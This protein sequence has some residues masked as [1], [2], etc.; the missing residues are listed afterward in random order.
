MGILPNFIVKANLKGY[1]PWPQE[2]DHRMSCKSSILLILLLLALYSCK[3]GARQAEAPE[4]PD[5]SGSVDSLSNA[6]AKHNMLNS[7][8]VGI[9]GVKTEQWKRF[10]RLS[11]IATDKELVAL[12]DHR[13]AVVRCYAFEAL[14]KRK[15]I[16]P[17]PI[18]LRHLSDTAY[19]STLNGC[20]GRERKAGDIFLEELTA[21]ANDPAG[22]RL[23]QSQKATVDSILVFDKNNSLDA[24]TALLLSLPPE[25]KYYGRLREMATTEQNRNA[26]IPLSR[27][28]KQQDK[29]LIAQLL[30][31]DDR[32]LQ[33]YGLAAVVHFPDPSFFPLLKKIA[34]QELQKETVSDGQQ[35]AMLYMAIVRYKD[36]P[37]RALLDKVLKQ[38]KGETFIRHADYIHQALKEYPHPIYN[39]L[40]D[41]VR[42]RLWTRG[43]GT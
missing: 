22:Y 15:H 34:Q 4:L 42:K 5:L 29:P 25:S 41:Q 31:Q 26:L 13:N 11:R 36:Q 28:Q 6:I 10:E 32:G 18:L 33:Y 16:D 24:K 39:G 38:A 7:A 3:S 40:L 27:Y 30:Q 23:T 8:A 19:V 12:T 1:W 9:A 35:A 14:L 21:R 43:S 2:H 17:F 20:F 37:S